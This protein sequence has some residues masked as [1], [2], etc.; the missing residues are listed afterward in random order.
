MK[1]SQN[2]IGAKLYRW[3]YSTNRMPQNLCPYF[4]KLVI[5]YTVLIPYSILSLPLILMDWKEPEHRTT[6]ERL[7]MGF[8]IWFLFFLVICMFSLFGLFIAIPTKDSFYSLMIVAGSMGWIA[9]I[10][11]GGIELYKHLKFKWETKDIKYDKDG[12]R[13]WEPAKE[14]KPNLIVEMVKAK[15]NKYCPKIDWK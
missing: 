9:T 15:Y 8:I 12:Y 7:G 5:M 6:G 14:K 3:F 13:I 2:S 10:V 4:W 1:L 11:I